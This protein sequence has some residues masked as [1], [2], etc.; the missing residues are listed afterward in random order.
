ML[1]DSV[2]LRK[3]VAGISLIGFP[4]AGVISSVF[5]ANEGTG[6]TG[7]DLYAIAVAHQGSI[8]LAAVI[9]IVSSILTVPALGGILHL[10]KGRGAGLVH[11][12]AGFALIG[13]FGHMGYAVWQMML[14]RVTVDS[15]GAAMIAYLDRTSVVTDA[16]LPML[17]AVALGL[18]LVAFAL[19][20]AGLTPLWVPGLILTAVVLEM[21]LDSTSVGESKWLPVAIW[22]AALV[23]FGYVGLRVL[24]MTVEEWANPREI[25]TASYV[26]APALT[27]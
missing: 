9:F 3:L 25:R 17:I 20:R 22:G 7:K 13:A 11:V 6:M 8:M 18:L 10:V 27:A 2:R 15:D 14:A 1:S 16:L 23:A 24:T 21:A 12:G 19:Y 26:T 4:L 5:D